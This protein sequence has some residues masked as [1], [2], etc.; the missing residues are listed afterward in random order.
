MWTRTKPLSVVCTSCREHDDCFGNVQGLDTVKVYTLADL[1][2]VIHCFPG[3]QRLY[4]WVKRI[5]GVNMHLGA[6][7]QTV[8]PNQR[9]LPGMGRLLGR[10]LVLPQTF[11]GFGTP[12]C[13][14]FLYYT[15]T[16]HGPS[17]K[18]L[19]PPDSHAHLVYDALL[20]SG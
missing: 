4:W 19:L 12:T 17:V 5:G 11:T 7:R 3:T 14:L 2:L 13:V 1:S 20:A 9:G 8:F 6:W 16:M 10:S 18:L 15:L